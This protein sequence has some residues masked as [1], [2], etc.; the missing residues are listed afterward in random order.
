MVVAARARAVA[1]GVVANL[2][3]LARS[4]REGVETRPGLGWGWLG[5]CDDPGVDSTFPSNYTMFASLFFL[6]WL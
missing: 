1:V 3:D 6:A 2:L 4:V 5:G